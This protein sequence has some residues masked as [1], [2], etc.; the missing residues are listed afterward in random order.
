MLLFFH[1]ISFRN[2]FVGDVDV[3][4]TVFF[5]SI[6]Q[7]NAMYKILSKDNAD[8]VEVEEEEEYERQTQKKKCEDK[9]YHSEMKKKGKQKEKGRKGSPSLIVISLEAECTEVIWNGP[10]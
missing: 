1:L 8:D 4:E 7:S 9:T 6:F 3:G 10:E 2:C 5:V